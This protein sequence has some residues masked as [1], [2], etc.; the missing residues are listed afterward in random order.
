MSITS[1]KNLSVI[2][3]DNTNE[4][5]LM[6]KLKYRFRVT[7]LGFATQ[8]S[9]ELT[10]QVVSIDRPKVKFEEVILD[11]YNSKVYI[12]GKPTFEALKLV[13]RDDANG[14]M[15]SLVG[16]QLQK[17]FDFLEQASARSGVDYKFTT[18][19]EMLD[20]GNGNFAPQILETTSCYGCFVQNADYGSL[21]YKSND[22]VEV[23]LTIRFDNMEQWG[24]DAKDTSTIGGI[25]ALVG[26]ETASSASTGAGSGLT[27]Q[28]QA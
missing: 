18:R 28:A 26:R 10:K 15:Q 6:P 7:F 17:Q 4:T 8:E 24:V 13:I 2:K 20:G 27:S 19:I 14:Q 16:Q 11:V 25:G 21:E 1:L 23:T 3:T 22:A 9:T 5:L 12:A